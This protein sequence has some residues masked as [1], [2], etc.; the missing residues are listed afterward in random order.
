[1]LISSLANRRSSAGQLGFFDHHALSGR[2]LAGG[3]EFPHDSLRGLSLSVLADDA[4]CDLLQRNLA[5]VHGLEPFRTLAV[6]GDVSG[7]IDAVAVDV[8]RIRVG[9]AL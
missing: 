9:G 3:S 2:H 7:S 1:A 4:I 8:L 5:A 6:G